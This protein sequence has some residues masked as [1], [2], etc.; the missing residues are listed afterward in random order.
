MT[1]VKLIFHVENFYRLQQSCEGYV[2]TGVCLSARGGVW[3]S[4]CWDTTTPGS[5]RY[6]PRAD[7]PHPRADTPQEQTPLKADTPPGADTSPRADTPQSRHSPQ[8]TATVADGT[9]PPGMHSCLI[10]WWFTNKS[11]PGSDKHIQWQIRDFRE[12]GAPT[13]DFV[14]FF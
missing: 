10:L 1:F 2:F 5:S 3:L 11:T 9:H 4:A 8:E 12:V 7:T 14:K 6:P 13:Y